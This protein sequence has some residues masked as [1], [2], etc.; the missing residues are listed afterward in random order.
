MRIRKENKSLQVTGACLDMV[1]H[2]TE[3]FV[4]TSFPERFAEYQKEFSCAANKLK[5]ER[6]AH[7]IYHVL[8]FRNTRSHETLSGMQQSRI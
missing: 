2:N 1:S 8:L 3:L 4:L 7:F 5:I 6:C